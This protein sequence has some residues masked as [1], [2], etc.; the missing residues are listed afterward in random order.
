MVAGDKGEVYPPSD[1]IDSVPLAD[2]KPARLN[3]AVY[4]PVLKTDPAVREL[5][6]DIRRLGLL[7][8]I[9]ITEDGVI[10]SGHRRRVAC[11][12]AGLK[13]VKVRRLA[14]V[15]STDPNF[16]EM[17]VS[18]N[19]QREK[20]TAEKVREAI[21]LTDPRAA[22]AEL[23]KQR[24]AL[25][26]RVAGRAA[27]LSVIDTVTA[28]KRS[29][30]TAAKRPMLEAA[31][32][33]LNANRPFWPL[34]LRQVHYRL[35][36]NPPPRNA[37]KPNEK[38]ANDTLSYQD[39]SDLLTRARLTG[40]VSWA[41][42]HDPTR[43]FTNWQLWQNTGPFVRDQLDGFL[44]GY[45]RDL[46]QT[47]PSYI[48]VIGEKMTVQSLAEGVASDYGVPVCIG[49]G[50]SSIEARHQIAQRYFRSGKDR[51]TLLILSDFDPEGENIGEGLAASLRDEFG[52]RHITPVKVAITAD[53]VTRF[54][55]TS[56][57]Q[58]KKGSSRTKGFTA[59]HGAAVYELEALA[60]ADLQTLIREA[61]ETVLDA[62][63]Y[64][65]EVEREQT[66]A[67]ELQAI[68]RAAQQALAGALPD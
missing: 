23:V 10:V 6:A 14:G 21:V 55:L 47:Q 66:D 28:A 64:E 40:E 65:A 50:Y 68:R 59:K 30:I 20:T 51:L 52:V 41:A 16:A 5:A 33:V 3:D 57:M 22:H 17:L 19:R 25:A 1:R 48:E 61:I 67:A 8:P 32:A 54:R 44:S 7:Q 12:L 34:T 39:L 45:H 9:D 13:V 31:I 38:Y 26:D 11:Q 53:H 4:K 15:R 29:K 27:D 24:R 37:S 60:P 42:I 2:L 62:R 36:N 46:L 49:R 58:A 35:L 63:L 43:P 18:F 56:S